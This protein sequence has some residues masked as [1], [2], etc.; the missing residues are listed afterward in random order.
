[1]GVDILT[2]DPFRLVKNWSRV[3]SFLQSQKG[4]VKMSTTVLL[5]NQADIC[6]DRGIGL[7]GGHAD[8]ARKTNSTE[9]LVWTSLLLEV[10]ATH[11]FQ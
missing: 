11:V 10:L 2:K 6:G 1:M 8:F 4:L 3:I 9:S 7:T 5:R